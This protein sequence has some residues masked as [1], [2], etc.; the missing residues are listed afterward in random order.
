MLISSPNPMID[1][2]SESPHRDDSS[3]WS[4]IGFVGESRQIEL[5]KVHFK[6]H[7]W[8]CLLLLMTQFFTITVTNICDIVAKLSFI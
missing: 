1:Y 6:H 7:I 3:K 5:I 2:L 4:K 8:L